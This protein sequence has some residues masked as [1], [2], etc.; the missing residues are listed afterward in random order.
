[1]NFIKIVIAKK[2]SGNTE[3]TL[4]IVNNKYTLPTI[5]EITFS[6]AAEGISLGY[7]NGIM[8]LI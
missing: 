6:K 3:N 7:I 1:M 5:P 4:T 8:N 2:I